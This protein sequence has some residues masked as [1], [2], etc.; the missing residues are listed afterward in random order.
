VDTVMIFGRK[1]N[2]APSI[3]ASRNPCT[4]SVPV[5][6]RFRSTASSK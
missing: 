5:A 1:R 3:T 4:V 6:T 2:R